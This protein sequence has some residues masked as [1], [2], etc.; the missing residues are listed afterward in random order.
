[1]CTRSSTLTSA[2]SLSLSL[3]LFPQVIH[4]GDLDYESAPHTWDNFLTA[5]LQ[6]MD[7]WA[8][9]GNQDSNCD[10]GSADAMGCKDNNNIDS[11]QGG[12]WDGRL[13]YA[14]VLRRHHPVD[15]NW[16]ARRF[17]IPSKHSMW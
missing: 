4:A 17:A 8:V 1:M 3:P 5:N 11:W 13:G 14:A 15:S 6:G 7:F 2:L 12:L 9:K 16:C 10:E